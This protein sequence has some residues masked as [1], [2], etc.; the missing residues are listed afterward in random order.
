MQTQYK[1]KSHAVTNALSFCL[2]TEDVFLVAKCYH[3]T[4][5]IC[6][7]NKI[8]LNSGSQSTIMS[9]RN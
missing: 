5:Q 3:M 1:V 8:H 9:K 2:Q 6:K 4:Q 7:S